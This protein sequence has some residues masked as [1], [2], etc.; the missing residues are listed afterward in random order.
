MPVSR[1]PVEFLQRHGLVDETL[2]PASRLAPEDLL[3]NFLPLHAPPQP[4]QSIL[5][6]CEGEPPPDRGTAQPWPHL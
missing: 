1:S 3:V 4:A 2:Q 6:A 5:R